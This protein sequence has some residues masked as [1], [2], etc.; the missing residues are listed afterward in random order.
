MCGC[1]EIVVCERGEVWIVSLRVVNR[2]E[3]KWKGM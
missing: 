1:K 3:V 2:L